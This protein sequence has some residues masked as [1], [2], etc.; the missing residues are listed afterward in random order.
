MR[1]RT[2]TPVRS[3]FTLIELLVV[4][5][6]IGV[7]IGLLLPAVQKV[8]EAAM[9]TENE[10]NMKQVLTATH[11]YHDVYHGF[12]SYYGYPSTYGA[13]MVL[14]TP[15][16]VLLPF[17]EQT[18][19]YESAYGPISYNYTYQYSGSYYSGYKE[20]YNGQTYSYGPVTTPP[21]NYNYSY[22]YGFNGL[23]ASRVSGIIKTY[24]T[25]TDPTLNGVP[26]PCSIFPNYNVFSWGGAMTMEKI[27]DGTSNTIFWAEGY[28]NCANSYSY[29]YSY[30]S[31]Y[32]YSYSYS[33]GSIRAWNYDPYATAY[34]YTNYYSWWDYT[35][36]DSTSP[37][38][39]SYH[40]TSNYSYSYTGYP[41][42]NTYG[43][44]DY[45]TYTYVPFQDR[46]PASN[47]DGSSA[48][49][50]TSAGLMVG[51]GDGSVRFLK[52]GIS[53]STFYAANTPN[54]GD[55]LGPDW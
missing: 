31:Y 30:G 26:S 17:I 29:S 35:Y 50:S 28:T 9:R 8:R 39:Y 54:S 47:C 19:Y 46:P 32:S 53:Q 20:V 25:R 44:Y 42:Y 11:S 38:G 45:T 3:G 21:S 6:I 33:Y 51:L 49:A 1:N 24:I 5:A 23:Q 7:L 43:S 48:Q 37:W 15:T 22:S 18:N 55:M 52:P 41:Y 12:P 27:T 2:H 16:F 14:G 13:G 34:Y 36:P 40:S 4:I 10:N